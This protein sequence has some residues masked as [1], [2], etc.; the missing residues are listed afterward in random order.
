[1]SP[2]GVSA[3]NVGIANGFLTTVV[4]GIS[5]TINGKSAFVGF[6]SKEQINVQAPDDTTQRPV[7]VVVANHGEVSAPFTAQLQPAAPALFQLGATSYG[8]ATRY[9]DY[10][11]IGNPATVPGTVA[12]KP[13]DI[14]TLWVTGLGPTQPREAAGKVVTTSA[15]DGEPGDRYRG[16]PQRERAW[17][18]QDGQ[19]H[20]SISD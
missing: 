8:I 18:G 13:G 16:K 7:S 11:V 17:G 10:A 1:M 15:A 14:L 4:D 5:V 12:A 19:R 9:P 6:I 3:L 20:R 2:T